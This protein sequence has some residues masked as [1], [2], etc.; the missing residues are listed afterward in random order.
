MVVRK[1]GEKM[2]KTRPEIRRLNHLHIRLNDFEQDE[3]EQI[4]L[5]TGQTVS[6]FVRIAILEKKERVRIYNEEKRKKENSI[7]QN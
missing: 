5:E 7:K 1:E 2:K 3:L 6:D 4:A